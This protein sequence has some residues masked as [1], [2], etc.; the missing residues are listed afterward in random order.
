MLAHRFSSV[1]DMTRQVVQVAEQVTFP[2]ATGWSPL[3][4]SIF[5]VVISSIL[6]LQGTG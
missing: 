4:L 3:V 2:A 6:V 1:S 5:L